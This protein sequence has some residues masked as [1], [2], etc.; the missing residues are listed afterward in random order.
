M[1]APT[2]YFPD[3][4]CEAFALYSLLERYGFEARQLQANITARTIGIA[5]TWHGRQVVLV[6]CAL[7]TT[8]S[9]LEAHAVWTTAQVIWPL[10]GP[11][12]HDWIYRNSK[13]RNHETKVLEVLR[14]KGV[15]PLTM[16]P[17]RELDTTTSNVQLNQPP[18]R[19]L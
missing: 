10:L 7:P 15:L 12:L 17:A 1:P 9:F 16:M 4:C 19:T 8:V 11:A 3:Y 13:I 18:G 5:L 6:A 14:L 2:L